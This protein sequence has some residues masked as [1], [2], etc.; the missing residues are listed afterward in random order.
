[1]IP[2]PELKAEF[3]EM[4]REFVKT[5][6]DRIYTIEEAT[7]IANE[8]VRFSEEA[9]KIFG[10]ENIE[11]LSATLSNETSREIAIM[12]LT[13]EISDDETIEYAL[14][15]EEMQEIFTKLEEIAEKMAKQI[16]QKAE[17]YLNALI[18]KD[19]S[20]PQTRGL[21]KILGSIEQLFSGLNTNLKPILLLEI[22]F[23][24]KILL[25]KLLRLIDKI[26][27]ERC[28]PQKKGK[29][30]S[31]FY[32][33][34]TDNPVFETNHYYYAI[35]LGSVYTLKNYFDSQKKD[36]YKDLFSSDEQSHSEQELNDMFAEIKNLSMFKTI[37]FS[38]SQGQTHLQ[39]LNLSQENTA[40]I[41]YG[42]ERVMFICKIIITKDPKNNF[43]VVLNRITGKLENNVSDLS[44]FIGEEAERNLRYILFKK[45]LE[46]LRNKKDDILPAP[47]TPKKPETTIQP[48][49]LETQT[50]TTDDDSQ[51]KLSLEKPLSDNPKE[52]PTTDDAI[53]K[54][55]EKAPPETPHP[56][57]TPGLFI[58]SGNEVKKALDTLLGKPTRISGSHYIYKGRS[59]R[60]FPIPLHG[61]TDTNPF[62]LKTCL[63]KFGITPEEFRE[64][65][66]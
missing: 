39:F 47:I 51:R 3:L 16:G 46:Y 62:I 26:L 31:F 54:R 34:K 18:N 49:V 53:S 19:D 41:F 10:A 52:S 61:N 15:L 66:N 11:A 25:K 17:Y 50:Q 32:H 29:I 30:I 20:K 37:N 43:S 64:T 14:L 59:G 57:N 58:L 6:R 24:S 65:V 9:K 23:F 12:N 42:T 60:T 56:K 5:Q 1:M 63:N 7:K 35:L 22:S 2:K 55:D 4:T 8:P 13:G 28:S 40:D 27:S 38:T 44:G 36:E 33:E 45:L 48:V 21:H